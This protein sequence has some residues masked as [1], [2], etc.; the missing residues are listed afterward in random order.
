[1]FLILC[2]FGVLWIVGAA[3]FVWALAAAAKK[4]EPARFEQREAIVLDK[5]A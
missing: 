3:L 5:A 1:M 2:I 4:P